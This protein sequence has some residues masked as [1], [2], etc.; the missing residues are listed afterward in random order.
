MRWCRSSLASLLALLAL[1]AL[2]AVAEAQRLSDS[3]FAYDTLY[4]GAGTITIEFGPGDRLFVAEKRGRLLSFSPPYSSPT[5][6]WDIQARVD[7]AD[8]SGLLGFALAPDFAT[9]RNFYVL[10]TTTTD[11]R[12]VRARM[13]TTFSGIESGSETTILSGLPRSTNIHKAGHIAFRP[14]EPDA[15]YVGIGDDG[16][17]ARSQMQT[18]YEGKILRIS[19]TDGRGLSDN[20]FYD[21]NPDSVRSRVW[22]IGLRNPFRFVFHPSLPAIYLSENGDST[23]RVSFVEA[24]S[25]GS[26]GLGGDGGGFLSPPDTRHR[27]MFTSSTP[28]SVIGIALATSGPFAV[29]GQPTLYVANMNATVQGM[30]RFRV[31]GTRMDTLTPLDPS[32][33]FLQGVPYGTGVHLQ[34]GPDGQLYLTSCSGDA[35]TGSYAIA[36]IRS[37]TGGSAPRAQFT[38]DPATGRGEAP[39]TVRFNDTSTDSDGTIATRAWEFGDG[40]T[41]SERSPTHTYGN[42]G[43]YTA[44]LTVIDDDGLRATREASIVA[45]ASSTL[46]IGGQVRDGRTLDLAPLAVATELRLYRDDG[47]PLPAFDGSNITTIPAGGVIDANAAVELS[48]TA[49]I[50]SVGESDSDGVQA[51]FAGFTVMGG[52]ADLSRD[53]IVSDTA[54]RGRVRDTTGAPARVDLGIARESQGA[55]YVIAGGRD[56]LSGSGLPLSGVA[57]RTESDALGFYYFPVRSGDAGVTFHVDAVADTG[58]DRYTATAFETPLAGGGLVERDIEVGL[59]DGGGGC[60]DISAIPETPRVDYATQIEPLWASCVGCHSAT[61]SNSGGLNLVDLSYDHLVNIPS[62]QVP[63]ILMVRPGDPTRSYLLEKLSCASPQRGAMMP[64]IGRFSIEQQALVRDWIAQGARRTPDS[65]AP[66]P[67]PAGDMTLIGW[68]SVGV[69]RRAPYAAGVIALLA[70]SILAVR[71]RRSRR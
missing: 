34:M 35:S 41:S 25:N 59:V 50:V 65:E 64:P 39:L 2:P 7:D 15:L 52:T 57:F 23:D 12:I 10:Y 51:V 26:W 24:G 22:A 36:R 45:V 32:A 1:A 11:Q 66:M 19:A 53:F 62:A 37:V 44:R 3:S 27:V 18:Q 49:I 43:T 9:T 56:Y 40:A 6:V 69:A 4:S 70:L 28:T 5:V 47:S 63:G 61:A 14:G 38:T 71:R 21:G 33:P 20:P 67:A 46:H 30:R 29:G 17:P 60:D 16:Q 8:E 58:T 42:A 68:C 55:P 31:G 48:G 54:I 13:N